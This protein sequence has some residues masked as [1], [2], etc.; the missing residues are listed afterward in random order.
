MPNVAAR[1]GDFELWFAQGLGV[2]EDELRVVRVYAGEALPD[3]GDYAGVVITGS[4]A[5][6]TDEEPWSLQTERWL[7]RAVEADSYV[8]GVCYGHQLLARALGGTVADN[9]RGRQIGTVDVTLTYHG[10]HDP[11]LGQMPTVMHVPVSHF[12][13]VTHLPE[14]AQLLATSPRDDNHAFSI[15][16][17]AW[18]VQFH[19]EFDADI[20]RGYVEARRDAIRA[21]AMDVEA[22]L[23]DARDTSHGGKLLR[24]FAT[25]VAG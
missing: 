12:Q 23:R 13:A 14:G 8:L 2:P 9:P 7:Q 15:G 1:R 16:E 5:M 10:K 3:P 20:V 18:G 4:P 19:P 17:R 22:L 21:E 6:V 11:L 24:S 25:I